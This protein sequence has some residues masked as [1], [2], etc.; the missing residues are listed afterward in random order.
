[1][2][3]SSILLL[4]NLNAMGQHGTGTLMMNRIPEQ[5][6]M[7]F[8]K[9]HRMQQGESQQ[10]VSDNVVVVKWMD[11]KSILVSMIL[12]LRRLMIASSKEPKFSEFAK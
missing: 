6:S 4:E 2:V 8:E 12:T 5:K 11:K 7:D 1:M 10:F 3:L 9:G